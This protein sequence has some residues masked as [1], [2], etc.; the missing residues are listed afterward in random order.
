MDASL[1]TRL[2]ELEDESRRF[3]KKYSE[4]RLKAEFIQD[5]ML[6]T[7]PILVDPYT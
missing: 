7:P 4:E 1:L 2:K 6:K 3:Q 5:N